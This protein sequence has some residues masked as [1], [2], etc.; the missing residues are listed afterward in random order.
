MNRL[1]IDNILIDTPI[2]DIVR[3]L[4]SE[5]T[6]GKLKDITVK[7]ENIVVTCPSH[8]DG[9][10]RHPSC[11]I[12]AGQSEETQYGVAHCFSCGYAATLPQFVADCFDKDLSFGKEWLKER[13]GQTFVTYALNLPPIELK[14]DKKKSYLD[15][16]ILDRFQNY[17]PYMTQRKMSNEVIEKFKIKYDNES[18]SIVFPVWDEQGRLK[19]LTRR[20]VV[21]KNFYID[22]D[23]EKPVY[24]LN[25]ILQQNIK[26]VYVTESQINCLTLHSW[27]YP[28]IGLIGTGTTSQYEILNRSGIRCYN[29]CLD[30]DEAGDKGI[31]RFLKNIRK[32]VIVNIIRIPRGKDVNDFS[33]EEFENILKSSY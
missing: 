3:Q 15:E 6:N 14:R 2:I 33:K 21:G 31:L 20:S 26:T 29:L 1:V 27:G 4:R 32:D 24:L 16:S 18:Q 30:G 23:I 7:G 25:Y 19:M 9:L 5:L 11:S 13:F 10:E 8:K 28:A 17:H 22:K 12:Y